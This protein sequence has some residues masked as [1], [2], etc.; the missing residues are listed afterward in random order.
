VTISPGTLVYIHGMTFAGILDEINAGAE[1]ARKAHGV[2]MQ[3]VLDVVRDMPAHIREAG[4]RFAIDSMDKGIVALGLGGTEAKFPPEQF[5]ELFRLA[6]HDFNT[7]THVTNVASYAVILAE[8][9]GWDQGDTLNQ[10]ATAAMLHDIGKRFIPSSILTKPAR[11]TP[12]ERA[13]IETHPQRGYE[14]LCERSELNFDQL[15]LVYQHHERVAGK[16]YPVGLGGDEIHPWARM[17][18][19]VD[20]F[21]AMTAIRP[22]RRPATAREAMDYICQSAGTHFDPEIVE[23]WN[24]AMK[25]N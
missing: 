16:G 15:M 5:T 6:R 24:T 13:I 8:R 4:A 7:F 20:V 3:W 22:Y 11:L 18:A 9:L 12:Q 23:C 1:R 21:D 2:R 25:K 14:E 17:L 19:V 10:I